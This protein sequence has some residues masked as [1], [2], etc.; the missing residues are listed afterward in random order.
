MPEYISRSFELTFPSEHIIDTLLV[1]L[2]PSEEEID[3]VEISSTRSSRSIG[4][5]PTRVEFIGAEEL[6]EKSNMKSGTIQTLLSE[7]TGIQMQQTSAA[8]GNQTIRIQGLDG[9]YTQILKDGFPLYA[10]YAGGLSIMQIPPLDLKQV[11]IIK[12][13]ASTL[14]GGGAVAGM[15]NLIGK[16]PV[17]DK[18]ELS[19][20]LN[21]TS[22]LGTDA[23]AFYSQRFKKTGLTLFAARNSNE[24]YDP[25]KNGFSAIPQFERYTFNPRLFYYFTEHTVLNIGLNAGMENRLGGD[26]RYIAGEGDSIHRFFEKNK[27]QRLS[28][29]LGFD[30]KFGKCSHISVK[31]SINVFERSIEQP[32]YFFG[33]KQLSSYSELSYADHGEK[34]EWVAGLNAWTDNFTENKQDSITAR[35]AESLILGAFVQNTL[36]LGKWFNIES[37]LRAD[38]AQT[39][40]KNHNR[41]DIFLL[42]RL[43]LLFKINSKLTSRVGGGLGYKTPGIFTEQAEARVFQNVRGID[44]K[45]VGPEKSYGA[46][47]DLNFRTAFGE[48]WTFSINQLFFYTNLQSP[49]VFNADSLVAGIYYF[50]NA[51]GH[52]DALGAETNVKIGYKDF[53]LFLGYT[54]VD[55]QNHFNGNFS[56]VPLTSNHRVNAVLMYEVEEKWRIGLEA[57]YFSSQTLSNGSSTP[58]YVTAGFMAERIWKHVNVFVNFENFTD[59]RQTRFENIYTGPLTHPQFKEIYAPLDGFVFN[60]GIKIRL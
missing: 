51:K 10:G 13:S 23:S 2:S 36:K 41:E 30:H 50:E 22:A 5:I 35:D 3:E 40:D 28:S 15:I 33:G 17:K 58:Q 8:S 46:N 26:M 43:S 32:G 39:G 20:L 60:A 25:A 57:Y 11:E 16:T 56:P 54:F 48:H 31:N 18:R 14:Y 42:P 52:I 24:A 19:F 34:T 47:A 21:G 55:A 27:T 6:D 29:Q 59:T 12:G 38:Y 1:Q 7:S 45:N 49:L 44:Y 53:K 9:R 4:D 37:G